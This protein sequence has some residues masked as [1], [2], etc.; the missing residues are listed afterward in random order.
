MNISEPFI[1]RPV[2]TTLLTIGI[3]LAGIV[4]FFL[5][6]VAA[7]PSVDFPAIFVNA[8]LPGASPETVSTSVTTPLERHLGAIAG[9]N[10]MTSSSSSGS[11]TV[12]MVF[13]LARNIDG[14]ARDVEAAIQAARADL[15]AA[16]RSNPG[17]RK[18]NPADQPT[19]ILALSSD[20]L[21][22]GQIY[23]SASTIV[24]QKLLQLEGVGDVSVGGSSLPAV[25]VE[26]N[27]RA[28]F[29]Y[30]IGLEDVRAAL[31][32][33]NANSPKGAVESGG[34]RY[35][36][37]VNDTASAASE[38]QSLVI[39]Y[40]NG[41][42]VRLSDVATVSD[43]VE[44]VR[45]IGLANGK[46]AVLVIVRRQPGANVIEVSQRVRAALPELRDA[47]PPSIE[48]TITNDRTEQIRA[49]LRDVE[50]T[51]LAAVVLVVLVVYFTLRDGRAA[52]IPAVAV[53]VSLLGTV[54]AMYMLGFTLDNLSLMALTV[55]TGFVVDDAIVMLENIS[56]HV[57]AG[58]PRLQAALR[59]AREVGFTVLAMSLSLIA[60]FLP[61]LLMGGLVGRTFRSF[62]VSL[63]ISIL[64][65][66]VVSLTTT[67]VMCAFLL[68]ERPPPRGR[69]MDAIERGLGILQRIYGHTL[70]T[71][72]AWPRTVLASLALTIVLNFYLFGVVPKGFFPQQDTGALQ[73][74]LVADQ[75]ISFQALEK[76]VRYVV[77]V[78]HAD[79]DVANVT[80]FAGG[81]GGGPMRGGTN[82]ASVF[83]GLKPLGVRNDST[84]HVLGRIRGKLSG[85]AGA[86]L[87]L[88]GAQ[89]IRAGGRQGNA[90]YQ[91]TLLADDLQTLKTWTPRLAEALGKAPEVEDVSSDQQ[92]RGMEV[93]LQVDRASAARLGVNLTQVDNTLY[94]A[95]G[96]RQVSTIFK[97]MN[98]YHV[99]MEVTPDFWQSPEALREVYVSTTGGALSGT[100]ASA[101]AAGTVAIG[102]AGSAQTAAT[103][104]ASA[105]LQRNLAQN[106]LTNSARGGASSAASIST[107]R[108]TMV[109][110]SA[111][112]SFGPSTTPLSISHQGPFV[113]NTISF[114]LAEGVSLSSATAAI[115]RTMK[116]I[117]VPVSIHGSFEGTARIFK[118]AIGNVPLLILSAILAVYIVLGI[119]YESLIHP[120]TIL[121]TLPSGGVGAV[122]AL[123][124]F[125]TEFSLIAMIGV[126]LLIGI[127]KKNA[128]MM[129]DVAIDRQRSEGLDPRSAI[130]AAC[131]QRFRPILM[132]SLAALLGALPLALNHGNGAEIR[133]PLGIAVVGG[134]IVSQVLT[135]YTT[136]V[137]YLYMDRL[138]QRRERRRAARRALHIAQSTT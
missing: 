82:T 41:S 48:V 40:R 15:P 134:L 126:I 103:Q 6:P 2:A 109:P 65:S 67:P 128:I 17:Y 12:V 114:N 104:S 61:I 108:E 29:K 35:Q 76:K 95:F 19:V 122:I 22:P 42:A 96:Q 89:D 84:D 56:R 43:S 79:P 23:D 94:D 64:V 31:S 85:L 123:L 80:A 20:T 70:D 26:L 119:L 53:P 135:L 130:H 7:M 66:L 3:A 49:S 83:V 5:M 112:S 46:P 69:F 87:Y 45:N 52:L 105:S 129:V 34:Q 21:T 99:V 58:M 13:D 124:L 11:A 27:P 28:L 118:Q 14:A 36:V 37:Y 116:D 86:R 72:L 77:D 138:R 10:E 90:Q 98:Q 88:Q 38:Y 101:A 51:L 63:S 9:V 106:Q 115:E 136:P 59:G 55:A 127:V 62:A 44:N 74:A 97:D 117:H 47:I 131:L 137:V 16:L 91:Y 71:A 81:G 111:F 100:Q 113:A 132:T 133:Q 120:V 25:R 4:A 8:Q 68:R 18:M 110:L 24:Q 107:S 75:S 102:Q 32:A 1:H 57:E 60:V 125:N 30:G 50:R 33:A 39:A 73:G 121:S 78:V 92:D 93:A 54:S